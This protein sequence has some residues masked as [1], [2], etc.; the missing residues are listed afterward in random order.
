[1]E[2]RHSAGFIHQKV[3]VISKHCLRTIDRIVEKRLKKAARE[4]KLDIRLAKGPPAR[5]NR[6]SLREAAKFPGKTRLVCYTIGT[7]P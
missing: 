7:F 1:M 6:S 5:G 2:L 4:I 3:N